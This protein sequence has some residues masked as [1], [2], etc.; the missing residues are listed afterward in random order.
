MSGIIYCSDIFCLLSVVASMA[1][2]IS[3]FFGGLATSAPPYRSCIDCG[4]LSCIDH[5][6]NNLN[7]A[8]DSSFPANLSKFHL[9]CLLMAYGRGS[10]KYWDSVCTFSCAVTSSQGVSSCATVL[11]HMYSQHPRGQCY[12]NHGL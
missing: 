11:L 10:S 4:R 3:V 9:F 1:I 6:I 12:C 7:S 8:D 5:S 2:A